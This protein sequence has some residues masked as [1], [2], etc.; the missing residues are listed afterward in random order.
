MARRTTLWKVK[1]ILRLWEKTAV[2]PT[3]GGSGEPAAPYYRWA[4]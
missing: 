3:V 1:Q 4:T 2:T